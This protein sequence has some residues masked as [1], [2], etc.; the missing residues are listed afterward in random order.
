MFLPSAQGATS[1][2]NAA[3]PHGMKTILLALFGALM[4]MGCA[5]TTSDSE[6]EEM[7]DT[8]SSIVDNSSS[9]DTSTLT[10]DDA[11]GLFG[12]ATN[13][14]GKG[15]ER[16]PVAFIKKLADV[17]K[18]VNITHS[19]IFQLR[20]TKVFRLGSFL[21]KPNSFLG[22][23]HLYGPADLPAT[24]VNDRF[25]ILH[26][27]VVVAG[28]GSCVRSDAERTSVPKAEAARLVAKLGGTRSDYELC[29]PATFVEEGNGMTLSVRVYLEG[30]RIVAWQAVS[31]SGG[32]HVNGPKATASYPPGIF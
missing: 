6:A 15:T 9:S 5:E 16:M 27:V 12:G 25:P 29:V 21:P 18:S 26:Q 2:T 8:S 22:S 3:L 24:S 23:K 20:N 10:W 17:L 4:T 1:G 28:L 32:V 14:S 11:D 31:A 7:G 19:A 13:A 30:Q